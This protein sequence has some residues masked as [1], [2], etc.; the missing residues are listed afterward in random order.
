MTTVAVGAR[1]RL[2]EAAM[3][4]RQRAEQIWA[5]HRVQQPT[6][7]G[8]V[9]RASGDR[10]AV[11]GGRRSKIPRRGSVNRDVWRTGSEH[12]EVVT[13]HDKNHP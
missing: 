3:E 11:V 7:Q 5:G 9:P 4:L 6:A 13:A 1:D 8:D 2:L 12:G 10:R